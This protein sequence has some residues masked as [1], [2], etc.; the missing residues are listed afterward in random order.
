MFLSVLFC[1][2]VVVGYGQNNIYS[3]Q[4]LTE[5][6]GLSSNVTRNIIQDSFGLIWIATDNGVNIYNGYS[7]EK[8]SLTKNKIEYSNVSDIICDNDNGVW[9][10]AN[11]LLGKYNYDKCNFD[12]FQLKKNIKI[13]NL[14]C[15]RNNNIWVGTN[16][17]LYFFNSKKLQFQNISYQNNNEKEISDSYILKTYIDKKNNIW[18]STILGC[19]RGRVLNS[20]ING[21]DLVDSI[22]K[23][24][25]VIVKD[26]LERVNGDLIFSS[27]EGLFLF[28]SKNDSDKNYFERIDVS[29]NS[30]FKGTSHILQD[31]NGVIWV[32]VNNSLRC[33]RLNDSVSFDLNRFNSAA[34]FSDEMIYPRLIDNNDNIWVSSN[35]GVYKLEENDYEIKLF[36]SYNKNRIQRKLENFIWSVHKEGNVIWTG[37][38]GGLSKI[39][40]K[41]N[42]D[43][44]YE[45]IVFKDQYET[46]VRSFTNIDE[47][48]MFIV[49]KSGVYRFNK[50]SLKRSS[51][52]LPVKNDNY[53]QRITK[54]NDSIVWIGTSKSI[55]R[56]NYISNKSNTYFLPSNVRKVN[57]F[58]F[59][60]DNDVLCGTSKALLM[61]DSRNDCFKL[62]DKD[63][64]LQGVLSLTQTDEGTIWAGT[65][66]K[67]LF[68]IYKKNNRYEAIR[69]KPR[70][71]RVPKTVYSLL[72]DK[73]NKLWASTNQGVC[74]IDYK[75]G[76]VRKFNAE[77]GCQSNDFNQE[78]FH[79][80]DFGL[81]LFGGIN[82]LNSFRKIQSRNTN[83]KNKVQITGVVI[84]GQKQP[85]KR[86]MVV[87]WNKRPIIFEFSNL[88]FNLSNKRTKYK[89]KLDDFDQS[90]IDVDVYNKVIYHAVPPGKY[91]FMVKAM[92]YDFN[93]S[94]TFLNLEVKGPIWK[95]TWFY[96]LVL[97]FSITI[98][99]LIYRF[100]LKQI[101][102]Q[103]D[104]DSYK[105]LNK[106]KEAMLKEIHHRVKNNL[107]VVN[108]LLSIQSRNINDEEVKLVFQKARDRIVSMSM[109][110]EK[111]YKSDD[112][113][114]INV[115]DHFT[116]LIE[117]LIVSYNVKKKIAIN[118]TIESGLVLTADTLMPLGL[119]IN[120]ILSNAFKHGFKGR[121]EGGIIM[122]LKKIT[123]SDKFT[124]IIG[125]NG[126]G[127]S[128]EDYDKPTDT[129][130][131]KLTKIFVRQLK[132]S[133]RLLD[134]PGTIFEITFVDIG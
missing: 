70:M 17:G 125:D 48:E 127:I 108:S 42:E 67:G 105:L 101:R 43:Y 26:I 103:V 49:Y 46:S 36:Q 63:I 117:N 104:R 66:Q 116:Q 95:K 134:L 38:E 7:I 24:R 80:D 102:L 27:T 111:M 52:Q 91:K 50:K 69:F 22:S 4:R 21:L 29:A 128:Q 131:K 13:T 90:W 14:Y 120:E 64:D 34:K 33:Y 79:I 62:I 115:E 77:D 9:V 16:K 123:D 121:D 100:R 12:N 72:I 112:L 51:V 96:W 55:I 107:Q 132:G 8:L 97:I 11:N 119:I 44:S 25:K 75:T 39:L 1:Y 3:V 59:T 92:D 30:Y 47:N 45:N 18:I 76:K 113:K 68:K 35:S 122:H 89:V 6:D 84:Q 5:S 65:F 15:D 37:S 28:K 58:F 60:K 78:A 32:G 23:K 85:V 98:L 54:Q 94:E 129:T 130:G 82:G 57:I 2:F 56:Y 40:L 88:D 93:E 41:D 109:L 124:L 31:S 73:F 10:S 61:Y 74:E 20:H 86:N 71:G 19:Y 81:I 118:I 110:H 83:F 106:E 133:L 53:F 126:V 99:Y 114:N 87:D